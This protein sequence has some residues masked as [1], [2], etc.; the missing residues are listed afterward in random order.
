MAIP[1]ILSFGA[2]NER[3]GKTAAGASTAELSITNDI[4]LEIEIYICIGE[5]LEHLVI[6]RGGL[7]ST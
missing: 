2:C 4:Y 5:V 1:L 6:N 3:L 7:L